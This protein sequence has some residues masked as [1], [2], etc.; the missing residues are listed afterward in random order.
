MRTVSWNHLP[1]FTIL[2]WWFVFRTKIVQNSHHHS[3]TLLPFGNLVRYSD[4]HWN[5]KLQVS[6]SLIK[7]FPVLSFV[8]LSRCWGRSRSGRDSGPPRSVGNHPNW[9]PKT[10]KVA[11]K[12]VIYVKTL[13]CRCPNRNLPKKL[14]FRSKHWNAVAQIKHL[15]RRIQL[16]FWGKSSGKTTPSWRHV[17]CSWK[18]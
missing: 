2:E 16:F 6:K 1:I 12:I 7:K 5:C 15:H 18:K 9:T 13:Q 10:K 8:L 4:P 17:S 14:L 11:K 3:N